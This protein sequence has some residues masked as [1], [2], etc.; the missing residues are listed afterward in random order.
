MK[1]D[2]MAP[3]SKSVP[4]LGEYLATRGA[5]EVASD[6]R[7]EALRANASTPNR[8]RQRVVRSPDQAFRAGGGG[9]SR[10]GYSVMFKQ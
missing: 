9:L 3:R 4:S 5:N 6:G 10:P 7:S 2:S 1:T 8:C